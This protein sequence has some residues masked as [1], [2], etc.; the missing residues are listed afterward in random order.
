[1]HF[2]EKGRKKKC[3]LVDILFDNRNEFPHEFLMEP[4]GFL[5][6]SVPELI[7]H[8]SKCEDLVAAKL[9]GERLAHAHLPSTKHGHQHFLLAHHTAALIIKDMLDPVILNVEQLRQL[10]ARVKVPNYLLL[11][12]ADLFLADKRAGYG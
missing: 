7:L 4:E 10:E 1:M 9:F 2:V 8:G 5:L 6:E 12:L 11:D 3:R